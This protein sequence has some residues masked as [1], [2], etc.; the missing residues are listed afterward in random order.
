MITLINGGYRTADNQPIAG[1]KLVLQLSSDAQLIATGHVVYGIKKEILLDASGNAPA[2]QIYSNAEL[3]PSTHYTVTLLSASGS[4]LWARPQRWQFSEA[5]GSTVDIGSIPESNAS[6]PSY[7]DAVVKNLSGAQ[8]IAS[9]SLSVPD[10]FVGPLTGSVVGNTTG[11]HTGPVTGNLTGDSAG[12][13]VGPVTGNLTGNSAGVHTGDVNGNLTGNSNG[14]HTGS[15]VSDSLKV[16]S[17]NGTPVTQIRLYNP[18]LTPSAINANTSQEQTF[19]VTGL[20]ATDTVFVNGPVQTVGI[21]LAQF[22]VSAADTL[23]LKFYNQNG[24]AQT[25]A[26]GTYKIVAIRT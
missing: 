20:A 21:T 1:A 18:T 13:H 12:T 5:A 8:T 6:S 19:T 15:V 2:T 11:T 14:A 23:A 22:R 10:G 7:P 26:S 17:A 25:P 4:H 16:G 24:S 9:G 3:T